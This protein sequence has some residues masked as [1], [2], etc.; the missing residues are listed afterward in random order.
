MI[1]VIDV[2]KFFKDGNNLHVAWRNRPTR[3]GFS[4]IDSQGE[5]NNSY[6]RKVGSKL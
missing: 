4:M 2:S 5:S 3:R 6:W 1:M